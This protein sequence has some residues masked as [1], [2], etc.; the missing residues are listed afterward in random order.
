M[1]RILTFKGHD[2][3]DV[4]AQENAAAK[5]RKPS[6]GGRPNHKA[7]SKPSCQAGGLKPKLSNAS[8][9]QQLPTAPQ[10]PQAPQTAPPIPQSQ[11]YVNSLAYQI[12]P[13]HVVK[14]GDYKQQLPAANSTG[15]SVNFS[16]GSNSSSNS[17]SPNQRTIHAMNTGSTSGSNSSL[18]ATQLHTNSCVVPASAAR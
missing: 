3:N 7:E 16:S 14:T 15:S 10:L 4:I 12:L 1:G 6:S 13:N 18:L 2:L 9:R 8:S 5:E 17:S 11:N